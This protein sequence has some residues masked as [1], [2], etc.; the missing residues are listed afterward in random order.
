MRLHDILLTEELAIHE[1]ALG[2][3]IARLSPFYNRLANSGDARIAVAGVGDS[4]IK[5]ETQLTIADFVNQRR[6]YE[7]TPDGLATIHVNDVLARGLTNVDRLLG[8]TDYNELLSELAMAGA[9]PAVRGILLDVN[10][11][12]GSVIGLQETRDAVIAARQ[13]KPLVSCIDLIGASAAYGLAVGANAVFASTSAIIGSIGTIAT[14]SNVSGLLAQL[15]VKVE[16]M[17]GGDLKAAGTP[18]RD[19]TRA[20]RDFLQGRVD[21]FS[22]A[23]RAWVQQN[24][25]AV[26]ASSMRG[27]WFTGAES[28]HLGLIDQVGSKADALAALRALA[29]L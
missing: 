21:M 7:I 17:T 11:P 16:H 14:Y 10:S 24:R 3:L 4:S 28:L 12:G 13:G 1:P 2:G 18:F 23:F 20:E 6:P 19:M 9:D 26:D 29:G 22:S 15:G 5:P 8:A 25:P 27:Q